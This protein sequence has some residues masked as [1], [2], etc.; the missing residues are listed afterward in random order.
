MDPIGF[1]CMV[2]KNI[3]TFFSQSYRFEKTFF[4]LKNVLSVFIHTVNKK[5]GPFDYHCMGG[6][7]IFF[8]I[9]SFVFHRRK[10]VIQI[11]K[12]I[13]ILN[14]FFKISSFLFYRRRKSYTFEMT[15]G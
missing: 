1:Y 8:N 15:Q 11:W 14:T 4:I 6:K 13:L 12:D 9:S 7:K 2:K 3:E 10:E 5:F